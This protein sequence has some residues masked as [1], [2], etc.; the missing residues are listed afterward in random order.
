LRVHSGV[1][2][3]F[4]FSAAIVATSTVSAHRRDELLQAVRLG[5]EPTHVD[6]ELDLSP[7]IAVADAVIADIDGDRD[8]SF[9][10]TEQHAYAR[11]VVA[12]LS[13]HVDGQPLVVDALQWQFPGIDALQRGEG[14]IRLRSVVTLPRMSEGE[15][16]L[17]LH[18][19]YRRDV[20]VYLANALVPLS[21]RVAITAQHRDVNQRD[22]IIDFS[23]RAPA[24]AVRW[25]LGTLAGVA[26]ASFGALLAALF[27]ARHRRRQ[28]SPGP[29]RSLIAQRDQRIDSA[30]AAG[31]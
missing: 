7:G 17:A 20:G 22:L 28:S 4:A 10:I 11:A 24:S 19:G 8:G 31:W 25:P 18:N 29:T 23:L 26:S 13:I 12:A 6:L 5:V 21:K 27:V 9:S 2:I 15:H 3:V 1:A 30:R 16:T 14:A